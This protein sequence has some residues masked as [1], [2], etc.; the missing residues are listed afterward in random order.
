M[1]LDLIYPLDKVVIAQPFGV[2][3][4]WYRANG[5]NV[6]GHNGIDMWTK[7]GDPVYATHDGYASYQIDANG[8]HGVVIITD[9]EYFFD[10]DKQEFISGEEA[11]KRGYVA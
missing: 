9:K 2:N 4:E 7:H 10:T 8:G 1:K 6:K 11:V 3:G 5:V